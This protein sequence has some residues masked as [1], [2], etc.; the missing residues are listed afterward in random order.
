MKKLALTLVLMLGAVGCI[1]FEGSF[2]ADETLKLIHTTMFG[3]EKTKVL[4]AGTYQT[5]FSFSSEDKMKLTFKRPGKDLDVKIKFPSNSDFPRRNGNIYLPASRTGQRYDI[6]GRINTEYSQS[7]RYSKRES[8][9]WTEYRTQCRTR[10]DSRGNCRQ[11]CDRVPYTRHGYQRVEYRYEYTDRE[12]HLELVKP[13]GAR[14][15]ADYNGTD[16]DS[17]KNYIFKGR[18]R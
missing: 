4:P 15:V 16:R 12:L 17:E 6:Q 11:V 1:N 8:C 10:C 18:C 5:E 14:T 7:R 13:R 2:K 9:T 3:N